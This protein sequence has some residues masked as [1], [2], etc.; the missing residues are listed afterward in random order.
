MSGILELVI[1]HK[2]VRK[3]TQQFQKQVNNSLKHKLK[4]RKQF[5][6]SRI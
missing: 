4:H 6:N 1:T 3:K 5:S 2:I